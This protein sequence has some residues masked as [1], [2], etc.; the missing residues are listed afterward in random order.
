LHPV[1]HFE[2]RTVVNF[3]ASAIGQKRKF[4]GPTLKACIAMLRLDRLLS[5]PA[6]SEPQFIALR[7]QAEKKRSMCS[8]ASGPEGSV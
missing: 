3:R 5:K 4:R 6:A 7:A 1:V 2:K 8:D